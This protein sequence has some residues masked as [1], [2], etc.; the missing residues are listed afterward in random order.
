MPPRALALIR[1]AGMAESAFPDR[2]KAAV[3]ECIDRRVTSAGPDEATSKAITEVRN[4][5]PALLAVVFMG[6]D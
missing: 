6:S 4:A 5:V 3:R 2:P 1:A